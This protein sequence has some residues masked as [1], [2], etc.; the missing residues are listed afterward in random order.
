MR[1]NTSRQTLARLAEPARAVGSNV[2]DMSGD[3]ARPMDLYMA[4]RPSPVLSQITRSDP[5]TSIVQSVLVR[6]R[7]C[8]ACLMHRRRQWTARAI[9]ETRSSVRTWF[10]TLTLRPDFQTWARMSALKALDAACHRDAQESEIFKR[11]ANAIAPELQRFLKR[12]RK[13]SSARLRYLLVCE[14]HKAGTPHFHMLLHEHEG[15][16]SKRVLEHCWRFGFSQWRLI[17]ADDPRASG[18]VCK[19]ISKETT[20]RPKA[21]LKYGSGGPLLATERLLGATQFLTKELEAPA[22]L[23]G[24]VRPGMVKPTETSM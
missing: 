20:L 21:S 9:A 12:A 8:E 15:S 6:C 24:A 2:T 7:K 18:Y 3:C 4:G 14:P 1:I 22:C 5:E 17:D 23:K 13:A 11:T 19:Y 16:I 10:G